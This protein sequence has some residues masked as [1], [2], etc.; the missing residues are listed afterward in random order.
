MAGS[1]RAVLGVV[2]ALVVCALTACAAEE[3]PGDG[4]DRSSS[5]GNSADRDTPC[6]SATAGSPG[7]T[8]PGTAEE[9]PGT[10]PGDSRTHT[11]DPSESCLIDSGVP[12]MPVDP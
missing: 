4:P 8:T 3:P 9:S 5:P 6:P 11:L 7:D 12:S 1:T 10:D 2:T